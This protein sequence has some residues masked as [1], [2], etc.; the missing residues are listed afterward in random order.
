MDISSTKPDWSREKKP[1]FSWV[2]S[3]SLLASIR[4]YQKYAKSKNPIFLII[5][6]IAVLRHRFWSVITG[7]DIPL[8]TQLGGGLLC[9]HPSGIVIHPD[10]KIGIN[11]LIFQ[12]VTIG[13]R[14]GRGLPIIGDHVLI[15]AGAKILG[16]V[17]I[18]NYSV[19]GANAVVMTDVPANSIAVGVPAVINR[20]SDSSIS[21]INIVSL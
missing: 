15:G 8:T 9:M 16:G 12:Q 20:R 17:S 2:P 18:G 7:A 19:I 5:K 21:E 4:Q 14:N 1:F 6:K 11:C 13:T 3:R 10:A